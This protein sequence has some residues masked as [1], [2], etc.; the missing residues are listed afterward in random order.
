MIALGVAVDCIV[1]LI[2][3]GT[4]AV[5]LV[6]TEIMLLVRPEDGQVP[7][8]TQPPSMRQRRLIWL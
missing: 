3:S 6:C 7:I 1:R 5:I 2:E 4:E 8:S